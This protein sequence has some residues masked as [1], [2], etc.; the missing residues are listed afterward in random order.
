MKKLQPKPAV[1]RDVV[2]RDLESI[3]PSDL[4]RPSVLLAITDLPEQRRALYLARVKEMLAR[5]DERAKA[6]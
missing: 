4:L 6:A 2:L 5:P 1:D 3:D